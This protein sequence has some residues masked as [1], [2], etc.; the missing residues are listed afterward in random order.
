MSY[1]NPPDLHP[2]IRSTLAAKDWDRARALLGQALRNPTAETYYLAAYATAD[3]QQRRAF[4][5]RSLEMDPAHQPAAEAL[6]RM[7]SQPGRNAARTAQVSSERSPQPTISR[8]ERQPFNWT[9]L[10]VACLAGVLFGLMTP[11]GGYGPAGSLYIPMGVA[12]VYVL[13]ALLHYV[14]RSLENNPLFYQIEVLA[15]WL[16]ALGTLAVLYDSTVGRLDSFFWTEGVLIPLAGLWVASAA[17][18]AAI[19]G[20][21]WLIARRRRKR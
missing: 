15:L 10:V 1:E 7:G 17:L 9:R 18:G 19:L 16:A 13:A 4:L 3:P 21:A 8:P 14:R 2:Q 5:E 6:Q 11:V 12:L 20:L